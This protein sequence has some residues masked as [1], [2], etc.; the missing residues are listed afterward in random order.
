ME[1]K[2]GRGGGILGRLGLYQLMFVL[3]IHINVCIVPVYV[4]PVCTQCVSRDDGREEG[5]GNR[6]RECCVF[7]FLA[8]FQAYCIFLFF[9]KSLDSKKQREMERD[10][11]LVRRETTDIK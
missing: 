4:Q 10:L 2:R 11:F 6:G 3:S 1:K 5:S 8:L 7:L 9:T